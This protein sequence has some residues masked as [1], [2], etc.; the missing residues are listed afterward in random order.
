[1]RE[2][3]LCELN[4]EKLVNFY[5]SELEARRRRPSLS[6]AGKRGANVNNKGGCW[7]G[8]VKCDR[9]NQRLWASWDG[10]VGNW[11]KLRAEP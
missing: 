5:I 3:A 10:D 1:M 2:A 4:E 8:D 6:V 9:V 11:V 7:C